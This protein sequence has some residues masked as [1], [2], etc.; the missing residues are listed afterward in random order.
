M[1]K[2][3]YVAKGPRKET[4]RKYYLALSDLHNDLLGLPEGRYYSGSEWVKDR[5]LPSTFLKEAAKGGLIDA[6]GAGKSGTLI[7]W[8][9]TKPS[10]VMARE[11]SLRITARNH[12][13]LVKNG[14]KEQPKKDVELISDEAFNEPMVKTLDI[15][16]K[17]EK[18][19]P[20]PRKANHERVV[21]T[22]KLF[23]VLTVW[24]TEWTIK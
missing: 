6:T 2:Q 1:S 12:V 24:K 9:T 16:V 13:L 11:L 15:P 18:V 22:W 7:K 3:G 20:K 5:K 10:L 19:E 21:K 14:K 8:S 17:Y 23:G 4:V